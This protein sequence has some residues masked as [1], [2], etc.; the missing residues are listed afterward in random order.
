MTP[1]QLAARFWQYAGMLGLSTETQALA[2]LAGGFF[3]WVLV[4]TLFVDGAR[5][6]RYGW[7]AWTR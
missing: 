4:T 6:A 7:R 3:V 5:V 2:A 1:E